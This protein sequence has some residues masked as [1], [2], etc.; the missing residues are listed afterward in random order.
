MSAVATATFRPPTPGRAVV[1][2]CQETFQDENFGVAAATWRLGV[3]S[4]DLFDL[5]LLF[6]VVASSVHEGAWHPEVGGDICQSTRVHNIYV[7]ITVAPP[8]TP[9]SLHLPLKPAC[10]FPPPLLP[11]FIAPPRPP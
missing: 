11:P 6:E 9:P 5:L 8:Y 3:S 1:C 7:P 2:Y 4:V 10:V